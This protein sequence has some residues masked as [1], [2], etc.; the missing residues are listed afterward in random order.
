MEVIDLIVDENKGIRG[1][2]VTVKTDQGDI[3]IFSMRK[4]MARRLMR[5]LFLQVG[6]DPKLGR[7]R[8]TLPDFVAEKGRE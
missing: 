8:D 1:V 2:N 5:A 6:L 7:G 3:F 4:K